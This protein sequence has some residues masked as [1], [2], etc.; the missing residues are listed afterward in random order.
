MPDEEQVRQ[1][2]EDTIQA[3]FKAWSSG[4]LDAPRRFLTEDPALEDSV[5]GRYEGWEAIRAYFG[6]GLDRYPDLKL[7]PSGRFWHRPDGVAFTWTMSATQTDSSLGPE[8]V[9]KPW[10]VDGMSFVVFEGDRIAEEVDYHDGGA[11]L[12]YLKAMEPERR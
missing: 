4:D 6:H 7:E 11:R 2:R 8:Y 12:R 1:A 3:L 9:G 10:R 5:G